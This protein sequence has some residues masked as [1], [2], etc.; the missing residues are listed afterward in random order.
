MSAILALIRSWRDKVFSR[1]W[2]IDCCP[3]PL[4]EDDDDPS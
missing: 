4:D 1:T 2:E 3:H